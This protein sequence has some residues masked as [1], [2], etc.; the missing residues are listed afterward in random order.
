MK[1]RVAVGTGLLVFLAGAV[2]QYF[3]HFVEPAGKGLALAGN[4]LNDIRPGG[5]SLT[6][7]IALALALVLGSVWVRSR[8]R[9]REQ[10]YARLANVYAGARRYRNAVW[11]RGAGVA[12]A[13]P[14]GPE[15]EEA[16]IETYRRQT[17]KSRASGTRARKKYTVAEGAKGGMESTPVTPGE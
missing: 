4:A 13:G 11:E 15:E 6:L 2:A 3:L 14:D 12:G 8:R 16:S 7:W 9:I 17:L 10:P 5:L 1:R